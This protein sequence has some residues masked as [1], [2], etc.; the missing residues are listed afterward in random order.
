[1]KLI[2]MRH[3]ECVGLDKSI[4]NGWRDFPLTENGKA[5]AKEAANKLKEIANIGK[6]DK[7][8]SSYLMRTRDTAKIIADE[9]GNLCVKQ[10]IR[11][12]ERHYGFF[13]G[14]KREDAYKYPEY[15][16]LSLSADR[17]DN[18]LIPLSDE[19]YE[20]QIEEYS[21]K[22]SMPKEQLYGILPRS[23][24]I[25]D[26]EER[27]ISFLEENIFVED[28]IE[29]TILIVGHANTV[30]LTV[31]YI[32]KLPFEEMTKLRFGTC[33]MT[34]YDLEYINREYVITDILHLNDEYTM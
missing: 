34:I 5:Q 10:D 23:E 17:L 7:V 28:N 30:K 4:I 20:K 8:F 29:D 6:I 9:F 13:Q 19:A 3:G 26:V 11:L 2:I 24:S 31:G 22:L 12:N 18:T 27:L 16:T 25:L 32:E 15:N 1:M 21:I 14:M 33:G